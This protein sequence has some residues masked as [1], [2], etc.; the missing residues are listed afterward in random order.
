[1]PGLQPIPVN[2][3]AEEWKDAKPQLMRALNYI[4]KDVYSWIGRIQGI[5][6]SD[7]IL[8]MGIHTHQSADQGGDY[9]WADITAAEVT[10][11]TAALAAVTA[12][13]MAGLG[14][15]TASRLVSADASGVP[16]SVTNLL[17]WI[18]AGTGISVTDDGDGTATI[19]NTITAFSQYTVV[20]HTTDANLALSDMKK[21]HIFDVETAG[22]D[23]I[24]SLPSVASGNIGDWVIIVRV[25]TASTLY[26]WA[27][28]ADTILDSSPGS[29][30]E[31]SD[32]TYDLSTF[33]PLLLTATR[34]GSG[35]GGFGI[36]GT[37]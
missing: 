23:L 12:A 30:I 25:G 1:M 14:G 18:G 33:T 21:I 15:L 35:P 32:A 28:D 6:N 11:L 29:V 19:A 24:A 37:R 8:S 2:I 22:T 5:E 3:S 10:W 20:T 17:S 7:P 9:A 13:K 34:W 4:I 26:I 27:N 31:C 36:W 16:A